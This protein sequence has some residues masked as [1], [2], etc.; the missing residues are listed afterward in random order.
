M[1]IGLHVLVVGCTES[2]DIVRDAL[3]LRGR[4]RL[5]PFGSYRDLSAAT[6][7]SPVDVAVLDY[8]LSL[9]DLIASAEHI[10]RYA[11]QTKI[12]LLG[13]VSE[14]LDDPLYDEWARGDLPQPSLLSI[15]ERLAMPN[16]HPSLPMRPAQPLL[17][18]ARQLQD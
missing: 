10:R 2:C 15:L 11:A 9:R 7:N 14:I 13:T 1:A 16:S 8:S 17:Q 4:C 5:S 6:F 3:Q 12:L 18:R